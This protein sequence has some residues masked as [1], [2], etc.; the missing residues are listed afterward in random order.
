MS[1]QNFCFTR[2]TSQP[3]LVLAIA[4]YLLVIMSSPSWAETP[5]K[6]A[7]QSP[8]TVDP[9]IRQVQ[10]NVDWLFFQIGRYIPQNNVL[11]LDYSFRVP[12][13][14]STKDVGPKT[15][16]TQRQ[17]LAVIDGLSQAGLLEESTPY[18]DARK[19]G[20]QHRMLILRTRQDHLI[21]DLG[22]D[23]KLLNNLRTI[24]KRVPD[25]VA[26]QLDAIIAARAE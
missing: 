19:A 21:F 5:R 4:I 16:I 20:E 12:E 7:N 8:R 11:A 17:A 25:H 23:Q 15:I 13:V 14:V 2:V 3:H 18:E 6:T 22:A 10:A 24:R 9:G 26:T 1:R